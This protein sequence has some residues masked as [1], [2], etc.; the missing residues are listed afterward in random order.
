[1]QKYVPPCSKISTDAA[2]LFQTSTILSSSVLLANHARPT[3]SLTVL[4]YTKIVL[5]FKRIQADW[6]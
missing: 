3:F 5:K 1:M 4:L 6:D 2:I